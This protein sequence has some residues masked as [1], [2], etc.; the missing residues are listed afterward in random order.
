MSKFYIIMF[1]LLWSNLGWTQTDYKQKRLDRERWQEYRDNYRYYP[2]ASS[3][4]SGGGGSEVTLDEESWGSGSNR[5]EG[6]G[7][8]Y[9]GQGSD[10]GRAFDR[11][12]QNE[13]QQR[14]VNSPEDSN[15]DFSLKGMGTI[16]YIFIIIVA[17]VILGAIIYY[18]MNRKKNEKVDSEP[19]EPEPEEINPLAIS[20]T[21]LQLKIEEC[22]ANKDYRTA[23]RLYYVFTLKA[24]AEKKWIDWKKEKTNVSYL[25]EMHGKEEFNDFQNCTQIYE[26]AWYGKVPVSEQQYQ[27]IEPVYRN[28]IL[29]LNPQA[30]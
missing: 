3:S 30:L 26:Y 28:L 13:R 16:G 23:I 9:G 7:D 12:T 20:K 24:L 10:N 14:A 18:L 29:H 15:R 2:P 8:G 11:K 1:L 19:Y 22:L 21:E 25:M 17:C 5:E 4:G 6:H 27:S